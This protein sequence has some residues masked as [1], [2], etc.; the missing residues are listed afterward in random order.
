MDSI[1]EF[2]VHENIANYLYLEGDPGN[3]QV[4]STVGGSRQSNGFNP[5]SAHMQQAGL[6]D[7]QGVADL[8]N[9][10]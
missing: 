1:T 10:R 8:P 6:R 3:W 9:P 4:R 5:G 2:P 7:P